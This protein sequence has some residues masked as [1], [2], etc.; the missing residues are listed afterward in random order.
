MPKDAKF[1]VKFVPVMSIALVA[2]AAS[3]LHS[4]TVAPGG[5]Y[6]ATVAPGGGLEITLAGQSTPSF[7]LGS[8]FS[9]AGS[10]P[11]L[12]EF[13]SVRA[14]GA[15]LQG[16]A[17]TV[18]RQ[19]HFEP[20]RVVV[21]DHITASKKNG[22]ALVGIEINHNVS[23]DGRVAEATVP[24]ALYPFACTSRN[25]DE[26]GSKL[27]RGTFG[28]PSVHAATADGKDVALL[29]LDD[30]LEQQ[31]YLW[32]QALLATRACRRRP[33]C[34]ERPANGWPHRFQLCP[35]ARRQL[36]DGVGSLPALWQLHRLL[37]L[38]E[39]GPRRSRR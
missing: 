20:H 19:Y 32:Q 21:H 3:L 2:T 27:H 16:D 9:E 28:N 13:N 14:D 37:L 39:Q 10:P 24:G 25:P 36:S 22:A 7:K 30:V 35:R 1:S 15:T 29:A 18:E 38:C 17:F 31:G 4:A 8:T 34:P 26:A 23:I 11:L 12:H 6:S 5:G 33:P